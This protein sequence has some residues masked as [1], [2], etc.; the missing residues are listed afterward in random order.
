MSTTDKYL[1]IVL[2]LY[3]VQT[4][5]FKNNNVTMINLNFEH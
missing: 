2:N 1:D 3:R 4:K 5:V